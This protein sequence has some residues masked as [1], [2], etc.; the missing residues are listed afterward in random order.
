M[1]SF[2]FRYWKS[3][4]AV[5]IVSYL[6]FTPGSEL[7]EF[8]PFVYFDKVVHMLMYMFLASAIIFDNRKLV[9]VPEKRT[10]LIISAIVFPVLYGGLVEILQGAFFAPRT[11][12]WLDWLADV[13]GVMAAY[14]ILTTIILKIKGNPK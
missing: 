2:I 8:N 14:G 4:L 12:D 9:L 7:P 13:I 3:L 10:L 5:V 1:K 11:S 6:S